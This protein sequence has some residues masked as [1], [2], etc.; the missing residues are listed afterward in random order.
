L[1]DRRGGNYKN[2]RTQGCCGKNRE[3]EKHLTLSGQRQKRSVDLIDRETGELTVV[4]TDDPMGYDA[5][6]HQSGLTGGC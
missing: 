1:L 6:D 2:G 3:L 4:G 5:M